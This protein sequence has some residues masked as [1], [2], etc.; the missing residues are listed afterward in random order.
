MGAKG[1][2]THVYVHD[3][4]QTI[5]CNDGEYDT[6]VTT[7]A[8][9]F[10]QK[11]GLMRELRRCVKKHGHLM[12]SARKDRMESFGYV[13][14]LKDLIASGEMVEL[15]QSVAPF[16]EGEPIQQVEKYKEESFHYMTLI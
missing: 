2:F 8:L 16:A 10:V 5:P 3:L 15:Y 6:L 1:A 9:M 7:A 4:Y 11:S 12:I 14:E 13:D